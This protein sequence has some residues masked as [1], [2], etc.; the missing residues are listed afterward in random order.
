MLVFPAYNLLNMFRPPQLPEPGGAGEACGAVLH[1]FHVHKA[2]RHGFR[3]K[4]GHSK[5]AATNTCSAG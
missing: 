1:K 2:A 5:G 4:G 3:G